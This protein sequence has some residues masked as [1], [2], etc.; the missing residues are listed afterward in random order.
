[1]NQVKI[2]Y[3]IDLRSRPNT[4]ELQ[5]FQINFHTWN[6]QRATNFHSTRDHDTKTY[7]S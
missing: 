6:F 1:M 2:R 3:S 5:A 7:H 4:L